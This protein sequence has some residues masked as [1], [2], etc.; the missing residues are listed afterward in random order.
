[1][2]NLMQWWKYPLNDAHEP[3]K[4]KVD[5]LLNDQSW[6]RE[7]MREHLQLYAQRDYSS[8]DDQG[9]IQALRADERIKLNAVKS[10]VDTVTGRVCAQDI[11][12]MFVT[13][14]GRWKQRLKARK[15]QK[16]VDGVK[17]EENHSAKSRRVFKDGGITGTGFLKVYWDSD[18]K[19]VGLDRVFPYEVVV[20]EK[21]ATS[22]I[23]RSYFQKSPVD[24]DVLKAIFPKHETFIDQ[25]PMHAV[26]SSTGMPL[27]EVFVYEAWHLPSGPKAGDGRHVICID[28]KTLQEA[29]WTFDFPPWVEWRWNELPLGYRG[30]GLAENQH[31]KQKECNYILRK[32]QQ[33][34]HVNANAWLMCPNSANIPEGFFQ[35]KQ[36]TVIPYDGNVKP[37]LIVQPVIHQQA[38]EILRWMWQSIF[39]DEGISQL[40]ASGHKPAD[41]ESG[42][43]MQTLQDIEQQRFAV[44]SRSWED[45]NVE[46]ARR[47]VETASKHVKGGKSTYMVKATHGRY[48]DQVD[49]EHLASDDYILQVFPTSA[50]PQHPG[51]KIG[52]VEKLLENQ[53]IDPHMAMMVM[54]FPDVDEF[55]SLELANLRNIMWVIDQVVYEGKDVQPKAFYDID[56]AIKQM[57]SAALRAEIE[58]APQEVLDKCAAWI[59]EA[60]AVKPPPPPVQA[61]RPGPQEPVGPAAPPQGP[62]GAGPGLAGPPM[63]PGPPQGPQQ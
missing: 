23:P 62:G 22:G 35:N 18:R 9:N 11:R 24:I 4:R 19:K 21:A 31:G 48:V 46:V 53:V 56:L 47:I 3:I 8:L 30:Q 34:L 38:F 61:Q 44:L 7:N 28:G 29:K 54:D 37:E 63:P 40:S 16:F 5:Q 51:A 2:D 1:M 58:G 12:A 26:V 41:V 25:V 14:G 27:G 55:N 45:F 10:G 13:A 60:K 43:A 57:Q 59:V 33:S 6:V 42:K 52:Y 36:G 50:L 39:E 17:Q 20:D 32:M 15:L 49:F